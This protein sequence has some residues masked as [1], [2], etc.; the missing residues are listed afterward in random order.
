[1][2]VPIHTWK[3]KAGG[4]LWDASSIASKISG[5]V[6]TWVDSHY[7]VPDAPPPPPPPGWSK[8]LVGIIGSN[9]STFN[10]MN[11]QVGYVTVRRTYDVSL[12]SSWAT[13]AAASDVAANR[14]SL[15][16]WKPDIFAFPGSTTQQNAFSAF[17]DTIPAGHECVIMAW[18][19]PEDNVSAGDWTLA[20]WG[21]LQNTIATIIKSKSRPELRTGFCLMGPW[22]FDTRSGRT[23]WAWESIID[24]NL[25]DLIGIDPYGTTAPPS[26]ASAYSLEQILTVN[27]S[28]SGS[29]GSAPSMM[30]KIKTWGKPISIMEFGKYYAGTAVCPEDVKG[31]WILEGYDWTKVWNQ[32]NPLTPIESMLYYNMTIISEDTP[33]AGVSLSAYADIVA[34]SKIAI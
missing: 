23:G 5:E 28:G 11:A 26:A 16:S 4:Q 31:Q 6:E 29:G 3:V 34:D 15:W 1:M 21:T 7:V 24:F 13:S 8:P 12:P 2:L 22:S 33:L 10:T 14:M 9:E 18:H 30:G 27:N 17:L 32:E 19:E 25:I 20:Q